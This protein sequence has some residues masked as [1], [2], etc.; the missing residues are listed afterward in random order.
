MVFSQRKAYQ[1]IWVIIIISSIL[2]LIIGSVLDLGND[3]V[4]YF[5]YAVQPDWNHFDHPP[6]VGIFIRLFTLNLTF[7]QEVMIRLPTIIGAAIN[8]WLIALCAKK[9]QNQQ[10]GIWAAL[11]YNVSIYTS[12]ISGTF[13][14][15]DSVQ[16]VF[17]LGALY[18]MIALVQ[19]PEDKRGQN[20]L[21]L[22]ICIGLAM[23]SKVH[24]IFLWFGYFGYCLF[25]QKA[26]F[27][28]PFLYL[29]VLITCLI[30][31]PILFWNIDNDFITYKFHSDRVAINHG[32]NPKSFL[33]TFIG[34]I[35]YANPLLAVV[36]FFAF[37]GLFQ[38]EHFIP[39]TY[40]KL[41]LW[42]SLP[43]IIC[44]TFFSLFR[45][46]LPHWSGPGFLGIMLISACYIDEKIQ[47][48]NLTAK[49]WLQASI[50]LI[51]MVVA[52][53]LPLVTKYPG[54]LGTQT[55]LELGDG[56]ATLDV[57]GWDQLSAAFAK[58]RKKDVASNK[59]KADAPILVHKW[60]PGSHI[61]YYVAYPLQMRLIGAGNLLDLHKFVWLNAQFSPLQKNEDAY[62]ITPSN[63]FTDPQIIYADLFHTF[64]IAATIPQKRGNKTAR[65]WYVY[66]LKRAKK[67]IGGESI[68]QLP[69]Q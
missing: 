24:G 10:T 17:W 57:S 9:I 61:Y 26:V 53:G 60:F 54:T 4:Y 21:L 25:S 5:T 46:M 51:L 18:L 42:T 50:V 33:T 55:G 35:L 45:D 67:E 47:R 27:K 13:I 59:M 22:G 31:S 38:K 69:R 30:I 40:L 32:I 1:P 43:I 44:T 20:F 63:N 16:L 19:N 65:L 23:M 11:I 36:Y 64:E 29:G 66:R 48:R 34:Q 49:R 6:L 12:I 2:R 62:Y 7:N 41:L 56:D 14:I 68:S 52:I 37:K 39:K 15:P 28:N 8:T 3:E 58:I